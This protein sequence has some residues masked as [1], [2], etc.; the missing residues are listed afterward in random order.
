MTQSFCGSGKAITGG[1]VG[2]QRKNVASIPRYRYY[3]RWALVCVKSGVISPGNYV[4][5]TIAAFYDGNQ[6]T[7]YEPLHKSCAALKEGKKR[8]C[9]PINEFLKHL[10]QPSYRVIHGTQKI[11][12]TDCVYRSC[13]Y[14]VKECI[15]PS[16]ASVF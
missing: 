11:G 6:V 12:D 9:A 3:K 5:H 14:V 10:G 15:D 7:F 2:F 8:Q 4:L 16:N 1:L 13:K